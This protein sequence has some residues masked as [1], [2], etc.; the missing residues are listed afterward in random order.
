QPDAPR[1]HTDK[2]GNRVDE[3]KVYERGDADSAL[4]QADVVIDQAY[5]TATALHNALEPHGC[6]A[7][8]RGDELTLYEST[9]GIFEVREQTAENLGLAQHQGRVI[10]QHM[11][12]GFG[13]KQIVWKQSII[14]ALLT[15]AAGRPVQL[16]LDRAAENLAAGNRNAT[17]QRAR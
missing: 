4:A 17:Q 2:P 12:G 16:M 10:K 9:Q 14:T 8:W 5:T 7:D 15:K 3:P 1:L 6:T 13:A 11:G